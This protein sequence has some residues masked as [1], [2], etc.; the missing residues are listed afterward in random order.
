[1]EAI[2]TTPPE[3]SPTPVPAPRPRLTLY[4]ATD[5]LLTVREWLEESEGELTPEIEALLARAE[6]DFE[7][8]CE[9]V[10]LFIREQ[11][12]EAAAIEQEVARLALRLKARQRTATNLKAYLQR[13]M[14]RAE[15]VEVKRPLVT[16][17]LQKSA[18]AVTAVL[19]GDGD[20]PA[21]RGDPA[22][23]PFLAEVP[24]SVRLDRKALIDA[25]R[26]GQ[27]IPAA[28][29]VEQRLHLRLR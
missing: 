3:A 5:A 27:P 10:A 4:D 1:M 12:A 29:T 25:W 16:L 9:R 11:E 17:R 28:V 7:T 6:G 14:E 18:P 24:A 13:E 19:V 23:A 26:A 2:D 21:L 8:K 20:L 15:R 22:W